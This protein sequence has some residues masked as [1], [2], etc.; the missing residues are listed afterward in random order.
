MLKILPQ[1]FERLLSAWE[2]ELPIPA[3]PPGAHLEE[4]C[5]PCAELVSGGPLDFAL[6]HF[7]FRTNELMAHRMTTSRLSLATWLP[8]SAPTKRFCPF[9][10]TEEPGLRL[11]VI[12][13]PFP[14]KAGA[15]P[16]K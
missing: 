9:C 15:P 5:R 8:G 3:M 6:V 11:Q 13:E 4:A 12:V 7:Q 2:A 10:G 14:L 16:L 1:L